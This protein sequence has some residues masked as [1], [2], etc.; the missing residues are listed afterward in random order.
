MGSDEGGL[1][2][3]V[4]GDAERFAA[5]FTQ[6]APAV[7]AFAYRRTGDWWVAEDVAAQTFLQAWQAWPQ[8]EERGVPAR[9]WIMRIA[10]GVLVDH[11]RR[12]R[13]EVAMRAGLIAAGGKEHGPLGM[14]DGQ[15]ESVRDA[16]RL[17]LAL[18]AL[19]AQQ[20]YALW[21]RYGADWMIAD[22]A[23]RIGRSPGATKQLLHR[24]LTALRTGVAVPV[25]SEVS[26][27]R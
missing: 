26:R 27:G 5:L 6:C 16:D 20:R 22:I 1:T 11:A 4:R 3:E 14:P 2:V 23:A 25:G 19:P 15:P 10:A 17:A 18:A 21:L 8:Y 7:R 24:T 9:A 12:Q 13:R